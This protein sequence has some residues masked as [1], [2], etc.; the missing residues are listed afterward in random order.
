MAPRMTIFAVVSAVHV[1]A[2]LSRP[3]A[4]MFGSSIGSLGAVGQLF[5][6]FYLATV[7]VLQP[8]NAIGFPVFAT[9]GTWPEPSVLGYVVATVLWLAAYFVVINL[10]ALLIQ[11][12][13]RDKAA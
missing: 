7:T 6:A 4:A 1:I 12:L 13:R 2:L 10:V 3:V 11:T 9:A 5:F 8:L